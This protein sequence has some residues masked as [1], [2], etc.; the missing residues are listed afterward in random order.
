MVYPSEMKNIQYCLE[1][2]PGKITFGSDSYPYSSALG[3]EETYSCD[4]FVSAG[5]R[6]FKLAGGLTHRIE[7]FAIVQRRHACQR[8]PVEAMVFEAL[9]AHT[10]GTKSGRIRS[11]SCDIRSMQSGIPPC[12]SPVCR[13]KICMGKVH[14]MANIEKHKCAH[15]ACW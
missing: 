7:A 9:A 12:G 5:R 6:Y 13:A 3:S 4:T 8:W 1:T 14:V 11:T 15:P 10:R 2:Y